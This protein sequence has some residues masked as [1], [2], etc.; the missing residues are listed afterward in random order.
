MSSAKA[1]GDLSAATCG[2]TDKSGTS[3]ACPAVAGVAAIVRQF[4]GQGKHQEFF[5][6]SF[7]A[8]AYNAT[9][10]SAALL[11]AIL[12]ASTISLTYGYDANY[13]SVNLAAFYGPGGGSGYDLSTPG[14]DF[15]QGESSSS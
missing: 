9:D 7:A 10:P 15:S 8:S 11:K 14:I 4:L 1:S 3:M 12:V 5:P 13:S 6:N 2:V